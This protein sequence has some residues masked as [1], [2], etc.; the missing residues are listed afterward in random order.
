MKKTFVVIAFIAIG[1]A[2]SVFAQEAVFSDISGKVEYQKVGADWRP[3]KSGVKIGK[4]TIVSTGFK[5]TA[6]LKL[7]DTTISLKPLTR[8]TLEALVKTQGG[9]QTQLYLLAGRVKA[10][11]PPQAGRTTDFRVKSPTATASVR[12]TGFEFDGINL[13]VDRGSVELKTPTGQYRMIAA[14]EFSYIVRGGAVA[15]PAAVVL[16][17]GLDRVADLIEQSASE[18]LSGNVGTP[19][20]EVPPAAVVPTGTL[21]ITVQ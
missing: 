1:S 16:E 11:V 17:S 9:T 21:S 4:G 20:K 15:L 12:G 7:D 6:A 13:I 14:G 2:A 19:T 5:S 18:T 8:L 10:D 3:A